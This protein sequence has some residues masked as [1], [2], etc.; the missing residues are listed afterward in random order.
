M[1]DGPGKGVP[2]RELSPP[3][4]S[5]GQRWA[6]RW[7]AARGAG[8]EEDGS[9]ILGRLS[10]VYLGENLS[11]WLSLVHMEG[12]HVSLLIKCSISARCP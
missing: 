5:W 9:V 7:D 12:H 10:H 1:T 4:R 6:R 11:S 8:L 3:G 2:P